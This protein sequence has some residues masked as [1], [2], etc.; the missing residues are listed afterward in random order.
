MTDKP[1][2]AQES[3]E[4]ASL[5]V[6]VWVD[7]LAHVQP[8]LSLCSYTCAEADAGGREC[9]RHCA[10]WLAQQPR[11]ERIKLTSPVL[12][13]LAACWRRGSSAITP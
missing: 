8:R 5:R 12:R 7:P 10:L 2:C 11:W 4:L 1:G 9:A 3:P 13:F 6:R